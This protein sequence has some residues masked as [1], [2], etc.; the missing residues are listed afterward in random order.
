M[1]DTFI[2]KLCQL[3]EH[4][5]QIM[6][7]TGDLGFGV[8][9]EFRER[10]PHQFINAGVAEQNMTGI[11]TGLAME[12]RIVFTYS[13]ANFPT[14]RCL[15]Q[16]RN[17]ACYHEAN[18]KIVAVGGG[19]SYGALGISHHA[20][21]DLA[22]M[23]SLPDI[24]ILSPCGYWETM[25]ATEAIVNTP[26][27][28][29]LRL[30]KTVGDDTPLNSGENFKV[31]KARLLAEGRD[32]AIIVTG[33]ILE[34]VWKA[35]EL[36]KTKGISAGIVCVHTLKPFDEKTILQT[37]RGIGK[38]ITV[39]EHTIFGGL[40]SAVAET[41]LD[42]GVHPVAFLRIG[43]EAG[44]SSIVGSQQYLRKCYGLDADSISTRIQAILGE[45][46]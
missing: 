7:I 42:H 36:L 4:N 29:Y 17:D 46:A 45:G 16:I 34:E 30:D 1:R 10:F 19:F 28:C 6:L 2:K 32:C 13:I 33:G 11:A 15:E 20:T 12:G 41:L 14:L 26:G 22:I 38:I 23:R 25:E 35:V 31:G 21:E 8:F 40:G 43:L 24:T 5:P 37:C 3:S 44:F 27:T 39:E 9:D 18:V